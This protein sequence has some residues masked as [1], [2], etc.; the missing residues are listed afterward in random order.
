MPTEHVEHQRCNLCATRLGVRTTKVKNKFEDHDRW[1]SW[2]TKNYSFKKVNPVG[3]E[4][5]RICT[6]STQNQR[7]AI[8]LHG[9]SI[10]K[11]RSSFHVPNLELLNPNLPCLSIHRKFMNNR[12]KT[13]IFDKFGEIWFVGFRM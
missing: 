3:F 13:C 10:S 1:I 11:F 9:T 8:E 7:H 6:C 2:R 4:P 12:E 5:T